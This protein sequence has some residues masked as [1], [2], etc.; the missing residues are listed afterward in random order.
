MR[1]NPFSLA[2][3]IALSV[4]MLTGCGSST[5]P[6]ISLTATRPAQVSP[7]LLAEPQPLPKPSRTE[8]GEMAG[9]QCQASLTDV[10][11]VAGAIRAA[12]ITLQDQVKAQESKEPASK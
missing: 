6:Q 10:Y 8:L 5:R 4:S 7:Y 3:C 2:L 11:D 9:A 12:F 1:H